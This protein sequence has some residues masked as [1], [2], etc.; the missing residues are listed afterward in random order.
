MRIDTSLCVRRYV[1]A[2]MHVNAI[3]ATCV[4][5][6]KG[7]EEWHIWSRPYATFAWPSCCGYLWW[8][9]MGP[10]GSLSS[11]LSATTLRY[12]SVLPG[13]AC[14]GK[15]SRNCLWLWPAVG[16]TSPQARACKRCLVGENCSSHAKG[17]C[18]TA[19]RVVAVTCRVGHRRILRA[20]RGG[21]SL[22]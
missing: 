20:A 3:R 22:Q 6:N 4:H 13:N 17:L 19:D 10:G 8:L 11:G 9:A 15:L 5:T 12:G 18:G 14:A 7:L 21:T 1:L 2:D 16:A